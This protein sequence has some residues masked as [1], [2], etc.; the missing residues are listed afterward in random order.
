MRV[1]RVANTI[2]SILVALK[3]HKLQ[4]QVHKI[5]NTLSNTLRIPYRQLAT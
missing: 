5:Q 2:P 4:Y 3:L 1:L